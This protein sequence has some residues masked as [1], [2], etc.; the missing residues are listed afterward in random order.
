ML[1]P[2]AWYWLGESY[3]VTT[4]Y[5]VALEAFQ[6]LLSQ[7][8]QSEKA[9]AALLKVGYTQYELRQVA[10]AKATLKEVIRKY[11][12]SKPASLAQDRLNRIQLQ[13]AN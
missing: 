8:P 9:P 4:N 7:F 2:N 11:P 12:G 13:S 10:A 3:Y 5:S 1:A 6:R